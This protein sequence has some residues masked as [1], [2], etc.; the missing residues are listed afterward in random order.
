MLLLCST[1]STADDLAAEAR[2]LRGDVPTGEQVRSQL[3]GI[4]RKREALQHDLALLEAELGTAAESLARLSAT[5][6]R[7]ASEIKELRALMR[8]MAVGMFIGD[9]SGPNWASASWPASEA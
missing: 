5:D 1:A 4:V 8:S 2:R 9:I 6:R 3:G 7:L